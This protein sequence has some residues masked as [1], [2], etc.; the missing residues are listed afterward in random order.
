MKLKELIEK[1]NAKVVE[2]GKIVEDAEKQERAMTEKETN[3]FN[4]LDKEVKELDGTIASAKRAQ[5]LTMTEQEKEE[6]KEKESQEE[7]EKRA[8]ENYLRGTETRADVNMTKGDNGVVIGTTIANKIIDKIVD[9][10]PIFSKS[11]RYNIKGNLEI[12]YYD[13]TSSAIIMEYADEFTEAESKS[14]KFKT[15]NLTE[16]LGRALTKISKSLI[17]NSSFDIVTFVIN[18][19]AVAA[20]RFIERE[21]LIGTENKIEGARGVTQIVKSASQ[22]AI[23]ADELIDVQEELPDV[24]QENAIWIMSKKT[25]KAIRKLK[26][27]EGN[28]LLNKDFNA[29]WGYTLLGKDVYVSSQSPEIEAGKKPILYGDMTGLACKV[30]EDINIEVLR[31]KYAEQHAIGVL[32]F[33]G[34]DAKVQDSQKLSA[35]QMAE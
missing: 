9:I 6:K 23:T 11:E 35:L 7:V 27:G 8:F 17:N 15:I 2:M 33:V 34:L 3:K 28:Y 12:P 26:D 19:I 32:A 13:E 25:R 24:Y 31:E 21:M 5:E 30:S 14:G 22:T 20:T 4:E 16:F 18:K 10:C 1:R 29:K